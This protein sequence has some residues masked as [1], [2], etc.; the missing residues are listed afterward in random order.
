MSEKAEMLENAELSLCFLEREF[1]LGFFV[2]MTHLMF[3]LV[4]ELFI[5]GPVHC[6]WMYPM[7]RYM[8]SLKDYV[9]TNARPE[10]SMAEGYAMEDTLGFCMEYMT[11]YKPTSRRVWDQEEDQSMYDEVVE[12]GGVRRPMSEELRKWT[13]SFV[14]QNAAVL[15]PYRRYRCLTSTTV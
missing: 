15:E 11:R 12:G 10:G 13:H 2:I 7:E 3:H 6:R 14:L 1:P 5:C 9:R 4:E 8:K